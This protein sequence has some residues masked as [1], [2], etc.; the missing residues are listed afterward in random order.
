MTQQEA[1]DMPKVFPSKNIFFFSFVCSLFAIFLEF[2]HHCEKILKKFSIKCIFSF[3]TN[4]FL[5]LLLAFFIF[6]IPLHSFRS[7]F[8]FV[9]FLHFYFIL[10]FFSLYFFPSTS[11]SICDIRVL[12][13]SSILFDRLFVGTTKIN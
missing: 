10:L 12:V 2:L 8:F 1:H 4:C 9:I 6:K 11:N 7:C 13:S 5:F 3:R